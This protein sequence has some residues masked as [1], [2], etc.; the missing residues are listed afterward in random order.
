M[1]SKISISLF[2]SREVH[3]DILFSEFGDEKCCEFRLDVKLVDLTTPSQF[4]FAPTDA[5]VESVLADD[6]IDG[7]DV[8]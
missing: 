4:E 7:D 2:G 6:W 3:V 5:E 1:L 8:L